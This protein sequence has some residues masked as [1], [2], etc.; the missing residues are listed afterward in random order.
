MIDGQ[1][2]WQEEVPCLGCFACLNYCPEESIQVESKWYLR[3]HT[4]TNG[5][6]HHPAITAS[7]IAEQKGM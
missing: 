4:T 7:D 3:S 1:P 2:L 6:Y 5:R